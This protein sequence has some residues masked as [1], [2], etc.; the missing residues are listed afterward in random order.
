MISIGPLQ[1]V[2]LSFAQ[3]PP[4]PGLFDQLQSLVDEARV[5]V[6]DGVLT[7]K[8]GDGEINV[9]EVPDLGIEEA[10]LL[11]TLA[12]SLF[13]HG[14]RHQLGTVIGAESGF[15]SGGPGDFG[16]SQDEL[17][18]IAD[19]IPRNSISLFLLIE[20]KWAIDLEQ[21]VVEVG[22]QVLANGSITP[23]ML[24]ALGDSALTETH[25]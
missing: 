18:E 20:H 6:M 3:H 15:L 23:A 25:D 10:I 4:P 16:L 8:N 21:A 22:G 14:T 12:R 7:A 11:G 19:L 13:G 17:Y 1:L 24:I 5:Q 9:V 2:V